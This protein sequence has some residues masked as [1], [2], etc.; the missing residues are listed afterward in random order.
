MDEAA[1]K[2]LPHVFDGVRGTS[3]SQP[4]SVCKTCPVK[5]QCL[6]FALATDSEGGVWGGII[7]DQRKGAA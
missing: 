2:D 1:C 4:L 6:A 7:L 5:A 3:W